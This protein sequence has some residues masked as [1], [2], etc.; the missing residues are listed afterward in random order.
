MFGQIQSYLDLMIVLALL[1][2][3]CFL[4][5]GILDKPPC[6]VE[7]YGTKALFS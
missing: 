6:Y 3:L 1:G 7:Q 2:F 5:F 4:S